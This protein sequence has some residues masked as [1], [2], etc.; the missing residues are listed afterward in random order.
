MKTTCYNWKEILDDVYFLLMKGGSKGYWKKRYK[1]KGNSGPGSHKRLAEFKAEVLNSFVE[2]KQVQQVIEWGSGDGNQLRKANYPHYIG[3]DIS[4]AA[5]KLCKRK[6]HND[7][8]KEF[9]CYDGGY[10]KVP[11]KADLALSLDVV[12][13]LVEDKVFQIYMHNLFES[14]NK[15]VCIY[16]SNYNQRIA[17]YI[18]HRRFTDFVT[19]KY[20][21]WKLIKYTKNKYPYDAKNPDNTSFADFYFYRKKE[22]ANGKV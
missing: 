15:Y 19:E 8:N 18:R 22:T 20:P 1:A 12:Y 9:I 11:H 17:A 21:E 14:S 6:F 10:Y 7:K 4:S 5:I 16:S 13:H 2:A 3:F